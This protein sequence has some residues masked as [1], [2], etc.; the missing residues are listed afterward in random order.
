M[1]TNDEEIR[2]ITLY[3]DQILAIEN[4]IKIINNKFCMLYNQINMFVNSND[5]KFKDDEI[6]KYNWCEDDNSSAAIKKLS[7]IKHELIKINDKIGNVV[8]NLDT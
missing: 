1:G 4:I 7:N 2:K 6:E 8:C 3:E 5:H